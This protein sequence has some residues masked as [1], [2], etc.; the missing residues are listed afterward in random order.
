MGLRTADRIVSGVGEATPRVAVVVAAYNAERFLEPTLQSLCAQTFRDWR[1]LVVD[2]GSADGTADVVR[3]HA[4]TDPRFELLIQ[5]NGGV[6]RA[7]NAGLA[8]LPVDQPFVVFLDSD[9][10]LL[11]EALESLVHALDERPD[12][13]GAYGLA[14]Y[15]DEHG[16]PI[17]VGEHPAKQRNRRRLQGGRLVEV[18]P[19]EDADFAVLAVSG[20]I[21]P[22]AAAMFRGPALQSVGGFDPSLPVQEDWEL[23]LR[24][25]RR[26]PFL[27]LDRQLA[28]YRQHGS[29][30][31]SNYY[32]N[33]YYQDK[34]RRMT[35]ESP[36][37]T[38][39]Q[40][41]LL[42][43]SS[44]AL[45]RLGMLHFGVLGKR[46]LLSRSPRGVAS[47][48]VGLGVLT[49]H[50]LTPGPA[51]PNRRLVRFTRRIQDASLAPATKG[52]GR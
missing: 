27:A 34:V 49:A 10:L 51:V 5:A 18:Q 14:E 6:S 9:D 36:Q 21:W 52:A 15:V 3:T 13:I 48:T 37:S 23:C 20:P 7:R 35:W 2:D 24:L 26:G 32:E 43:G 30:L 45:Q 22:P 46:A 33:V 19:T 25:S 11:P 39:E 16:V 44:R 47:A 42:S 38:D 40:R 41:R 17:R 28:W 29:G 50:L 4:A 8:R 12:A 31:T 1:C